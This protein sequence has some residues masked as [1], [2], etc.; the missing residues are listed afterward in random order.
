MAVNRVSGLGNAGYF[1][2]GSPSV[3]DDTGEEEVV[4]SPDQTEGSGNSIVPN[5]VVACGSVN[6]VVVIC[7]IV[8]GFWSKVF[9]ISGPGPES[10]SS[11]T[12]ES[13]NIGWGEIGP[14]WVN[15]ACSGN[16]GAWKE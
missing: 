10:V 13:G 3:S 12:S 14:S 9:V 11:G 5:C 15:T 2:S 8:V 4:E 6:G 16:G 1:G 7:G